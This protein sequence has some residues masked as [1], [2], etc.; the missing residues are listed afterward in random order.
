MVVALKTS[1]CRQGDVAAF[2]YNNKILIRRVIALPGETV[3]M[4]EE[5]TVYV[6]GS[7]LSEPYLVLVNPVF[8]LAQSI[9]IVKAVFTASPG[10]SLPNRN[11]VSFH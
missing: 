1:R 2:Y 8:I 3:E 5:G 6:N 7:P 11:S 10:Y 4:D 9:R